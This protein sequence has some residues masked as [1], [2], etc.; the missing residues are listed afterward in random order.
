MA[1]TVRVSRLTLAFAEF[2]GTFA[3][4]FIDAGGA[5]IG[6]VSHDVSLEARAFA[7]GL[8][9]LTMIYAIGNVSGAHINPAVTAAFALRGVF[10]WRRLPLYWVAQMLGAVAAAWFLRA[11]FGDVGHLGVT[12]PQM[13]I[14]SAFFMELALSTLLITVILGVATQHKMVGPNAAIPVGAAVALDGLIGKPVSG[15]SMNPARSLGPALVAGHFSGLWIYLLA[16]LLAAALS[17]VVV[18]LAQG[19]RKSGESEAARG[20]H[21]KD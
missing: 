7:A 1:D 2:F 13:G 5:M 8:T 18:A 15:A 4:T 21:K 16:P 19:R 17:V 11:L 12:R 9:V 6:A 10:P 20:S 3:L 14:A